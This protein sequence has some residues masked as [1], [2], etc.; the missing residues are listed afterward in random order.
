ML[1]GWIV[2]RLHRPKGFSQVLAFLLWWLAWN[3]PRIIVLVVNSF[4]HERYG[5][6][7]VGAIEWTT[8]TALC[9]ALGGFLSIGKPSGETRTEAAEP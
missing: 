3:A 9:I 4:D 7:L 5:P 8:L 2:G 6:Y 1:T